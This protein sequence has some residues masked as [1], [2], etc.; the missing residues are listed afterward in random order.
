MF[1]D[2]AYLHAAQVVSLLVC[3]FSFVQNQDDWISQIFLLFFMFRGRW[4][5]G[6]F[7]CICVVIRMMIIDFNHLF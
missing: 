3:F 4:G 5:L 1:W 7:F 6:A 2:L